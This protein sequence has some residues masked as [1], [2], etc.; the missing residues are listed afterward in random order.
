[1]AQSAAIDGR[2]SDPDDR[3]TEDAKNVASEMAHV[4]CEGLCEWFTVVMGAICFCGYIVVVVVGAR[5]CVSGSLR[6][7]VVAVVVLL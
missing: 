4:V 7:I 2:L 5:T 6:F 3:I 1:V